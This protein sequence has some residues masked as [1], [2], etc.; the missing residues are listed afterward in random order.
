[1]MPPPSFHE[2]NPARQPRAGPSILLLQ[3]LG[4]MQIAGLNPSVILSEAKDLKLHY[5]ILRRLRGS[6]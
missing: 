1:M 4:R 3:G 5:E 2:I 6:G